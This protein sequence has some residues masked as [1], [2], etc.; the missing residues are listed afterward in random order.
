MGQ[1]YSFRCDNCTY[2]AEVSGCPDIGSL[3][4]TETAICL[5]CHELVDV[6]SEVHEFGC[7]AGGH[8]QEL[9]DRVGHCPLCHGSNT[10]PWGRNREFLLDP[11]GFAVADPVEE[12]ADWGPCPKCSAPMRS[13]GLVALWD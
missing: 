6:V 3:V 13:Q 8:E 5:D 12:G 1:T 7:R 4:A 9:R 10:K 11:A 2:V